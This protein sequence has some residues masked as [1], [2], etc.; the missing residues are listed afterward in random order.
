MSWLPALASHPAGGM[1]LKQ[2]AAFVLWWWEAPIGWTSDLDWG[3][4]SAT[5]Q[6]AIW[7]RDA[8]DP[9]PNCAHP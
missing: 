6:L 5:C 3:S 9:E 4:G 1:G 2:F 7:G 8:G